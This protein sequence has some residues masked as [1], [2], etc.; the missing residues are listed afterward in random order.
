M[1]R[2]EVR[3]HSRLHF[4][5]TSLG[6]H[7]NQPQ[8]GGIGVMLQTPGVHLQVVPAERFSA[9]GILQERVKKFAMRITERS[10]LSSLPELSVHVIAAPPEHTGL[11]VGSQLGHAVAAGICEALGFPW[12]DP[13]RLAQLTG[14]GQ[15]SAVGTYGFLLGGLIADAGHLPQDPLGSLTAREEI[16]RQWRFVLITPQGESGCSG[17][18]EERGFCQLPPVPPDVTAR[19]DQL[20]EHELIPAV[21]SKNFA[22]FSA[23]LFEY[24]C[25]A[26]KCFAKAQGGTFST[27]H[28]ANIVAWL[29]DQGIT[30]VG[31][32][33]WGPT[34]FALCQTP[35]AADELMTL[36]KCQFPFDQNTLHCSEPANQGAG[37]TIA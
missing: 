35:H 25:L 15:R 31:Q 3:T 29:R 12:R 11:G 32:S 14:R 22:Q 17:T 4:G 9:T 20:I 36:L 1:K 13:L 28:S 37:I 18:A 30:G 7:E 27:P 5:L 10:H 19:M 21:R 24:G 6:H 23:A 8:F 2:V 16:P 34:V 33:S 26:G